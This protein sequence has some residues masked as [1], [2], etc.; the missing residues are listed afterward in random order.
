MVRQ[1][2]RRGAIMGTYP[3]F[4]ILLDEDRIREDVCN[5]LAR[6]ERIVGSVEISGS[7][8]QVPSVQGHHKHAIT[9][10]LGPTEQTLSELVVLWPVELEPGID[11][12]IV[13]FGWVGAE[14]GVFVNLLK[15][16]AGGR[17]KR[18][19]YLEVRCRGRRSTIGFIWAELGLYADRCD[20]QRS[21]VVTAKEARAAVELGERD[22]SQHRR[23]CYTA[24]SADSVWGQYSYQQR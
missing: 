3:T 5:S 22:I 12:A 1:I 24:Q 18:K 7:P 13:V 21:L 16:T 15:R 14:A 8:A 9:S 2:R 17:G 11:T 10:F 19:G 20:H 6:Q 4:T 23:H